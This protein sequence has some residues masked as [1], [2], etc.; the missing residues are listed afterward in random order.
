M[1]TLLEAFKA[2]VEASHQGTSFPPSGPTVIPISIPMPMPMPLFS[3]EATGT[4]AAKP[5]AASAT[6]T[7]TS[8][9]QRKEDV[10]FSSIALASLEAEKKL[11]AMADTTVKLSKIQIL[12][13][14][15]SAER[16]IAGDLVGGAVSSGLHALTRARYNARTPELDAELRALE[17]A[18]LLTYIP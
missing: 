7:V 9:M 14:M 4:P 6:D 16:R 8:A 5:F 1:E 11:L 2:A 18:P 15:I 17:C 3:K 12:R 10:G 13:R